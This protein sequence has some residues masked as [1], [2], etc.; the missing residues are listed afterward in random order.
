MKDS[1]VYSKK[2]YTYL[3]LLIG[4]VFLFFANGKWIL[5]IAAYI[6]PLLL[7]RFLRLQKPLIG[8]VFIVIAGWISN[9]FVL[10]G[11]L[12]VSG[13][14]FYILTFMISLITSLIFL[15][16]RIYTRKIKGFISTLIFPSAY[17]IMDFITISTNPSGSY[18]TMA[19]TQ[20]YLPLLQILSVTGVWGVTFI[21]MWS[22]SVINWLWDEGF[23]R[24]RLKQAFMAFAIPVI[25]IILAGQIRLAFDDSGPTVRVASINISKEALH[26]RYNSNDYS[27]VAKSNDLFLTNCA[28]AAGSGAKIVFGIETVIRLPYDKE[29]DFVNRAK[30]VASTNDIYLG[31]PMEVLQEGSPEVLS[32]NKIVWISPDGNILT[33]YHKGKPTPG[34]GDYGDGILKHFDTPYGRICS[35]ICFDMDFPAYIN[36]ISSQ[37]IDIM[38]VPGMDWREITPYHTYVASFRAIEH[39]FNLVRAATKGM[40]ASFNYKGELISSHNYYTNDDLIMYSDIPMAGQKTLYSLLGDYFAW[41][42]VL[43]FIAST[44]VFA[45]ALWMG[46][47]KAE[48]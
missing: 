45:R 33:S 41:L 5:P 35:A 26:D 36:Q 9:I 18:G 8:F 42:C 25:L 23:E 3:Y 13:T 44:V 34:E 15:L 43:F 12:P 2:I 39:G 20:N 30:A 22:A 29:E 24:P 37:E 46:R 31:L 27:L 21:I 1:E 17:V 6:A 32:M 7:I 38:L 10:E 47:K 48:S 16:D 14:F 28:V 19:H 4:F 11:I 40:S